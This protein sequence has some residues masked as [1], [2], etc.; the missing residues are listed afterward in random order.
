MSKAPSAKVTPR[1]RRRWLLWIVAGAG[2]A[3]LACVGIV[4]GGWLAVRQRFA[5]TPDTHDLD[6]RLAAQA[7][8]YLASRPHSALV[9]GVVQDGRSAIYGFGA[10]PDGSTPD[11]D[12]VYE[13]GSITKVFT[14]VTLATMVEGGEVAVTDSLGTLLPDRTGLYS[15]A[16]RSSP[17]VSLITLGQLTTHT[18]GLPRLPQ[19]LSDVELTSNDPYAGYSLDRLWQDLSGVELNNAPGVSY[20]Y[21]NFGAGVLGQVLADQAGVDYATVLADRVTEPLGLA[22]TTLSL[23]ADQRARFVPGFVLGTD[24]SAPPWEMNALAPAGGL[25]STARDLMAFIAANLD[26]AAG[27]RPI[28]RALAL[29]HNELYSGFGVQQAYGWVMQ[30]QIW[31]QR[32]H[33][34]NGGTGG[35]TSYLAIDFENRAGIVILSNYGDAM[36]GNTDLDG[37]GLV[38]L[39]LIARVSLP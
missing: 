37:L 23:S 34:H 36:A 22:D 5:D 13:I 35:Y 27:G 26:A 38:A 18:S 8:D 24:E 1:P 7:E 39:P 32:V 11:G 6:A 3:L 20:E 14:A 30:E 19:S 9:I 17:A 16:T 12:T 4:A 31:G 15:G 29:S 25:K 28:D 33:W 10:L 21:S 2:I